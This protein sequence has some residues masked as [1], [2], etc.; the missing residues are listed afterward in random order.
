MQYVNA[1]YI[2]YLLRPSYPNTTIGVV[3]DDPIDP[4]P[5]IAAFQK[6]SQGT[7]EWRVDDVLYSIV[8]VRSGRHTFWYIHNILGW[9]HLFVSFGHGPCFLW[10]RGLG[11]N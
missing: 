2:V 1:I 10:P 8:L 6:E 7:V 5:E 3:G 11:C 9:F 4:E